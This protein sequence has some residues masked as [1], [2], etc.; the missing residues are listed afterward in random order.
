MKASLSKTFLPEQSQTAGQIRVRRH[1][2][3]PFRPRLWPQ[4]PFESEHPHS[5]AIYA[6]WDQEF[7]I[8]RVNCALSHH[9]GWQWRRQSTFRHICS[10]PRWAF[11][12]TSEAASPS[13]F[14]Q[15]LMQSLMQSRIA[16]HIAPVDPCK[17]TPTTKPVRWIYFHVHSRPC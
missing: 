12:T 7:N 4:H 9:V 2:L 11:C 6:R 16:P 5:I 1:L 10:H 3:T 8:V 13:S 14:M 15:S 17:C